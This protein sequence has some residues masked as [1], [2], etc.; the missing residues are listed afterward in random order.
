ME[1]QQLTSMQDLE[2][3]ISE[4]P[5]LYIRYSEGP[6]A[7]DSRGSLDTE[8]Q[9][10]LPGLSVNPLAPES[11]WSRPLTDW[12]ARQ[13]CQYKTLQEKN[14]ERRA[15]V[16]SGR[17]VAHGPDCEPLLTEVKV[18]AKLSDTVLEEAETLYKQRFNAGRGPED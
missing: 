10:E 18:I 7:D 8:S 5:E 2:E 17:E 13:L 11:W 9:L 14:P 15:W 3:L 6:E 12:L 16:V 1:L 4:A